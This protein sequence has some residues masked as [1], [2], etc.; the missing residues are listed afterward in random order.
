MYF[1]D[2]LL[3]FYVAL[4][5]EKKPGPNPQPQP[6]ENN[7]FFYGGDLSGRGPPLPLFPD[8]NKHGPRS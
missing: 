6:W 2:T 7:F 4:F 1:Q 8:L 5:F 3:R